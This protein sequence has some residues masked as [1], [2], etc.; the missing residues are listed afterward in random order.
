MDLPTADDVAAAR[1]RIA[2][3]VRRTPVV[4]VEAAAFG[5]PDPLTL[6]LELLQHTASFKPRGAFTTILAA[7]DTGAGVVAASGGNHGLAVAYA[8][9]VLGV[10][11]EIFVP[12]AVS[13][14]KLARLRRL[15]AVVT[16]TGD[17]YADA[18]VASRVRAAESGALQIHAYDAP[19]VLAG[20]GTVALELLED[21]PDVDTVVV[22]VGGGGL[23]GGILCGLAG[24]ARVVAVEPRRIPT[25]HAALAAAGPVDVDV[26]G[27]AA[28]SL[29]ARRIGALGFAAATRAAAQETAVG[30]ALTS[31]L[32]SD[33]D[34]LDARH[35]LWDQLRVAAEAGGATALAALTSGAY[36]PAP[37]E[38]VAV[39]VCGGNT[40][41]ADLERR[42]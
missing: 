34:I 22:A 23:L 26:S 14:V 21:V 33:D 24:R 13:P 32:V 6:K 30:P 4:A 7:G 31:M 36:R 2:G 20:Q 42:S 9:G 27:V 35:R 11:A 38:R 40:D 17:F 16:V 18:L 15:G 29:G 37:G 25:L 10:R 28:D 41:P 39:V 3:Y 12:T 5:T 8:A 19:G 1:E